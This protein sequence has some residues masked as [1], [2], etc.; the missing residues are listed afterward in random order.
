MFYETLKLA[1]QAMLRNPMRSFLTVLGIVIG[2]AAVIAMVTIGN[3]TT[4]KVTEQLGKLGSNMLFVVPGQFGPGRASTQAK[5]FTSKDV[6]AVWNQISGIRVVAPVAQSTATII[7]GGESRSSTVVGT[8][9]DYLTA[10][11]WTIVAG[12][13]FV[14]AEERGSAVCMVGETVRSKLFGNASALGADIRVGKISCDVIGVLGK[15]GQ[16]G[17]GRD[18]DDV[19]LMPLRTFQRRI[20]GNSDVG[21]IMVSARAGSS[22]KKVQGDIERLMRERRGIIAGK[23]DDFSV[24]DMTQIAATLSGTTTILTGLLGAVAAVSLLVGGIGIMNIMLVSVTERT[25]EI[26][27]RLAIGALE[28]QVLTQFLVEATVLALFGGIVGILL[29]LG[30]AYVAGAYL[31]VPFVTSPSIILIAFAFSA[32]IGTGFGYFPAR[33]AARLNPIE[34][35]RHE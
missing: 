19:V 27:I 11:D 10:G 25:R 6:A 30:L 7:F 21:S 23:E 13:G 3:G 5:S 29:G 33:Q 4:A 15:K 2:V 34:A 17:M 22:T 28:R 26:G 31:D 1:A 8:T 18:Q 24:N 35:L 9:S 16:S 14:E 32:L 12:R 20:A